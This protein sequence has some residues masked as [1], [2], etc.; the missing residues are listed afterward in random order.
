MLFKFIGVKEN[1]VIKY[2]ISYD[3]AYCAMMV[4][5]F[6]RILTDASSAVLLEA[7]RAG[8]VHVML[9]ELTFLK[10]SLGRSKV[11]AQYS[12]IHTRLAP[13]KRCDH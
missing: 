12:S 10:D 6:L 1:N 13:S 11:I 8:F 7:A 3:G 4:H 2:D 9:K 5:E